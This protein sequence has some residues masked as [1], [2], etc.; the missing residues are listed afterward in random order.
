MY[1]NANCTMSANDSIG[2]LDLDSTYS[3]TLDLGS[4][5]LTLTGNGF[6]A[7]GLYGGTVTNG[8]LA[9]TGNGF[10]QNGG[11]IGTAYID[12]GT[13][14]YNLVSGN[15]NATSGTPLDITVR[16]GGTLD[17]SGNLTIGDNI[18]ILSGGFGVF[19]TAITTGDSIAN[20][21]V[22]TV[23]N[24]GTLD[25][26]ALALT[27]AS[28][29]TYIANSGLV[30]KTN[31][32]VDTGLSF[33]IQNVAT[34]AVLSVENGTLQIDDGSP[35]HTGDAVYQSAGATK[36]YNGATLMILRDYTQNAGT[37]SAMGVASGTSVSTLSTTGIASANIIGG[38]V[39]LSDGTA[40]HRT[41]L[42]AGTVSFFFTT[43]TSLSFGINPGATDNDLLE[44]KQTTLGLTV[45][46]VLDTSNLGAGVVVPSQMWDFLMGV[47]NNSINGFLTASTGGK[48]YAMAKDATGGIY[49]LDT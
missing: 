31:A 21:A 37:L 7:G 33:G 14:T 32:T 6:F 47:G 28:T 36:I 24:G 12:I 41:M 34:T 42:D 11:T 22:I 25:L 2:V 29:S 13:A 48:P 27:R 20:G 3:G 1:S 5:T 23:S 16:N 49:Q 18:N 17:V 38:T 10:T 45:T 8:T 9:I 46:A 19:E 26:E 4:R 40:N 39:V 35:G 15:I 44:T 30:E 43:G